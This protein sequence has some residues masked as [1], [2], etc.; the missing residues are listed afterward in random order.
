MCIN[1]TESEDFCSI[2][3]A[4]TVVHLYLLVHL[5]LYSA[6]SPF[7]C[8]IFFLFFFLIIVSSQWGAAHAEIKV[9]FG[10]NTELKYVLP[11]KPT[12]GQYM[13]IHSTLTA[14]EFFLAY[15]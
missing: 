13:A 9:P 11:L 4:Q 14:R 6:V 12:A 5:I 8:K 15:F 2:T 10:E 1:V 3:D 7:I